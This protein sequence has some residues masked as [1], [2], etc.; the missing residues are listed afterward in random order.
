MKIESLTT[1]EDINAL[2]LEVEHGKLMDELSTA[3]RDKRAVRKWS[4]SI[5][6]EKAAASRAAV[7]QAEMG[8]GNPTL[9]T[10]LAIA[11]TLGYKVKIDLVR[12]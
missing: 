6:I 2:Q 7:I 4:Q 3:I 10:I 9:K 11:L 5:L 8:R 1:Q 12:Q